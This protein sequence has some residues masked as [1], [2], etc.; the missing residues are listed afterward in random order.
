MKAEL[1]VIESQRDYEAARALV[2]SLMNAATPEDGARLRAQAAIVAAHEAR[3]HS[4]RRVDPIDAIK[5]RMDQMGMKRSDLVKIIGSKS[6]VSE[7]LNR[8]R[9]LSLAMIRRLHKELKI[10]AEVLIRA[11]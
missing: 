1:I 9:P 5:F 11:A 3:V 4:P 10:P 2:S 6:K 8:K 7:I